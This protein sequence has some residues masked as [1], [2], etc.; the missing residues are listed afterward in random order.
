[1]AVGTR[2]GSIVLELTGT[3]KG[4]SSMLRDAIKQSKTLAKSFETVTVSANQVVTNL[5]TVNNSALSFAQAQARLAV[6]QGKPAQAAQIL[7][8]ALQGIPQTT[9]Q[10]VNAT[11]QLTNVQKIAAGTAQNFGDKLKTLASQVGFFG[12]L[13]IGKQVLDFTSDL[14]KSGNELEKAEAY[15][16][17]LAGST[18]RYNEVIALANKQQQTFGG[19]LAENIRSLGTFVNVSNRTGVQLQLLENLARRL[20]VLDPVQGFQGAAIALKEFES[21]MNIAAIKSV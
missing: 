18:E 10:A 2:G 15:M 7:Q 6:A 14:I 3:D 1:M 11:T 21:G 4:L 16:R 19:S 20:A 8:N 13:F 9:V 12:G 5:R 17:A